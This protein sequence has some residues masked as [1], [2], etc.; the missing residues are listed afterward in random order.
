[1]PFEIGSKSNSIY[2][3]LD[4]SVVIRVIILDNDESTRIKHNV[5]KN[6]NF[7]SDLVFDTSERLADRNMT[8]QN[9]DIFDNGFQ[10]RN[11]NKKQFVDPVPQL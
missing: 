1:M 7:V 10:N 2:S 8:H 11:P 3:V 6:P 5:I 4:K 9:D